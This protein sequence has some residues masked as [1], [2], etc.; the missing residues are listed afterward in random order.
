MFFKIEQKNRA[1]K[2]LLQ[3]N[4]CLAACIAKSKHFIIAINKYLCNMLCHI[5][6]YS[7]IL[8]IEYN[9]FHSLTSRPN[10]FQI[11][12]RRFQLSC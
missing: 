12:G 11:F 3:L 1:V 10:D 7:P 8:E 9:R 6:H 2:T 4:A 5:F